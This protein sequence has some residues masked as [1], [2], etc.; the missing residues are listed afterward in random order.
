MNIIGNLPRDYEDRKTSLLDVNQYNS[1]HICL[2]VSVGVDVHVHTYTGTS[3]S[4]RSTLGEVFQYYL[5]CIL[6]Q[7]SVI[8]PDVIDLTWL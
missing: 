1:L 2:C 5:P 7:A 3:R 4:Y 6:S 8:E